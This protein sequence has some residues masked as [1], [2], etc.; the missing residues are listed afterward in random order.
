LLGSLFLISGVDRIHEARFVDAA[1]VEME[2]HQ[3]IEFGL[4]HWHLERDVHIVG[5]FLRVA[6]KEFEDL[7]ERHRFGVGRRVR[8]AGSSR[9]SHADGPDILGV[10][11]S[12]LDDGFVPDQ[13][14]GALLGQ[15]HALLPQFSPAR[16]STLAS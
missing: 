16:A 6:L 14:H 3:R 5:V 15:F 13:L 9:V 7:L 10:P 12:G 2:R 4:R 8:L 11:I 1:G